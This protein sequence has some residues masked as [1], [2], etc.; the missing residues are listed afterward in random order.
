MMMRQSAD[1][2]W[3]GLPVRVQA[4]MLAASL[5]PWLWLGIELVRWGR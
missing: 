4:G 2:W 5:A 3:W 1:A